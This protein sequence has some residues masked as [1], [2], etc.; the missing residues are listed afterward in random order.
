MI[1]WNRKNMTKAALALAVVLAGALAVWFLMSRKRENMSDDERR[2]KARKKHQHFKRKNQCGDK[3]DGGCDGV[4]K[5]KESDDGSFKWK[6]KTEEEYCDDKGEGW[7]WNGSQ[8]VD[9]EQYAESYA[10][11]HGQN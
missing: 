9:A 3:P 5:C 7:F 4:W 1:R 10:Q 8:C 6:C 2:E 11:A